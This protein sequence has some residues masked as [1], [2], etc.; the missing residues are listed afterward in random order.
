MVDDI[1]AA[2]RSL[3]LTKTELGEPHIDMPDLSDK[4]IVVIG[5]SFPSGFGF[6]FARVAVEESNA[7]YVLMTAPNFKE[8]SKMNQ[9]AKEY[10]A[11]EVDSGICDVTDAQ[12]IKQLRETVGNQG[13]DAIVVAPAFLDP[14]YFKVGT[15]WSDVHYDDQEAC[16]DVTRRC[17][18]KITGYFRE[19][20]RERNG[21]VY[22]VTFALNPPG[23]PIGHV[24]AELEALVLNRM[25]P[26]L[27]KSGI[28]A[29]V[30]SLG[31]F[32]SVSSL[33]AKAIDPIIREVA[34]AVGV[35]IK[36]LGEMARECV[37]DLATPHT[38]QLLSHDNAIRA[39]AA[40]NPDI[41]QQIYQK[42]L[43]RA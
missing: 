42:Y 4:R 30:F 36:P 7:G 32:D 12:T 8:Q 10:I 37:A 14:K 2:V 22:G 40:A 23:Y 29:N 41:V 21:S 1:K 17:I 31:A 13:I 39:A 9:S 25:A 27:A 19:Q 43:D 5:A 15:L 26:C 3:K 34:A 16:R 6:N 33:A 38:G 28:R 24:K 11:G 35:E 20:L 18:G